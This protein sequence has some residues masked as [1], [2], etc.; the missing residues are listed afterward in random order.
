MGRVYLGEHTIMKRQVALKILPKTMGADPASLARFYREARAVA[1]LNHPNIVQAYDIDQEGELHYIV[2]E[3]V[4]GLSIQAYIKQ[5]GRLPWPEAC[6]CICQAADALQHAHLAGL[7]HR[8]IKPGN[9]LIDK[10]NTVKLLD[11]GLAVFHEDTD[12]EGEP[13]TL[14][15]DENVLGTADYLAPEQALDSH[16]VDI[17]ADIYSLGGTF[18]FMLTTSVPFPRGERGPEAVMASKQAAAT[19]AGACTGCA[20]RGCQ[21]RGTD[22][23]QE[24]GRPLFDACG[25]HRCTETLCQDC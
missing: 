6:T 12:E 1:A 20:R 17:R 14:T 10:S 25:G 2:M 15:N 7:I 5:N 9:L 19:G 4:E 8:D 21:D 24:T 23:G 11:L 22:D 3:Y 13:L 18:Y 16:N